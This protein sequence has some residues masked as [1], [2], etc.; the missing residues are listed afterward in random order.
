[1]KKLLRELAA[2]DAEEVY[3]LR[4]ELRV[5]GYYS[6]SEAV[7]LA[8]SLVPLDGLPKG[9]KMTRT[10]A[11]FDY[12]DNIQATLD[13]IAKGNIFSGRNSNRLNAAQKHHFARLLNALGYSH[14]RW[15]R[16]LE[17]PGCP[18]KTIVQG[19]VHTVTP[20]SDTD[21]MISPWGSL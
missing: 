12:I 7:D 14:E 3:S 1:M 11:F 13:E 19:R 2:L 16:H 21:T 5:I 18:T 20:D 17:A 10:V 9:M 6:Y 15:L 8:I 4:V